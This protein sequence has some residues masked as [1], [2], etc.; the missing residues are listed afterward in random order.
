MCLALAADYSAEWRKQ[1]S[2]RL[3]KSNLDRFEAQN[4]SMVILETEA[5]GKNME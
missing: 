2:I 4:T 5:G 1:K 3:L